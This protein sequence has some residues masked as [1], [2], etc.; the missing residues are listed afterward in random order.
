MGD[1]ARRADGR[2][3]VVV[4]AGAGTV[5]CAG[6]DVTGCRRRVGYTRRREP[7]RRDRGVARC[8]PRS[9][10]LP[11]P[12]IGRIHGAALG[13]GAGLAAVCD[14]VVAA[15]HAVFGFTE[16]KLGILPAMISPFVAARRSAARPRASCFS[17]ARDFR[18]RARKEI[19]LVHAV[20]P[21]A[22]LDADRRRGTSP[23]SWP[24]GHEPSPP[25]RR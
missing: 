15:D 1:E 7:A 10:D 5:F 9:T 8:S 17:P 6:A 19:G 20:V 22:E 13:G 18:R 23:S 11:V 14:I 24:P 25:R 4:L 3:R 16:V 12:L 2:L 21:L